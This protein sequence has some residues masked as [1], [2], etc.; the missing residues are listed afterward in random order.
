MNHPE[1]GVQRAKSFDAHVE[2]D[3]HSEEARQHQ[4]REP[5]TAEEYEE[6]ASHEVALPLRF[7]KRRQ[8]YQATEGTGIGNS[9]QRGRDAPATAAL[10]LPKCGP[11]KPTA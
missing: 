3:T 9:R 11:A 6:N 2:G 10:L 1:Q 4:Q 5:Q 8:V 7:G